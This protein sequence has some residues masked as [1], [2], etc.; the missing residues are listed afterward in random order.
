MILAHLFEVD[1][2]L[3]ELVHRLVKVPHPDLAKVTRVVLV[4]VR[5]VMMLPTSHTS[6]TGM[7]AM[8]SYTTVASGDIAPAIGKGLALLTWVGLGDEEDAFLGL[9]VGLIRLTAVV[10]LIFE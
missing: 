7:F 8:L 9:R 10:S 2:W 5:S 1:R 4:E 6:S 3:P